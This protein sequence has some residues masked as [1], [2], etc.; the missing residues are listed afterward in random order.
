[1]TDN[2]KS[3]NQLSRDI[4]HRKIS[5]VCAGF[6]KYTSTPLWVWEAGFIVAA[7]MGGIGVV[8]YI[9]LTMLMPVETS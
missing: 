6:A 4:A 1:M 5:G 3:L 2:D 7:F 9:A 8:A